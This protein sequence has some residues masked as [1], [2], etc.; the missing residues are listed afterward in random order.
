MNIR[1]RNA[2]EEDYTAAESMMRQV[3]QMHADWRPDIFRYHEPVLPQELFEQA[4]KEKTFFLAEYEGQTA[5]ILYIRYRHI[6][7]PVLVTRNTIFVDTM[8]VDEQYRGR[9]I[10]HAFF[11]FLRE[12]K[13]QKGFDGIE[14]EVNARNTAA[15][16]MYEEY[17]FTVESLNMELL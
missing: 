6:E 11:D 17:G 2:E 10:G 12:L 9:G 8:A 5:G 13:R 7:D 3:H 1:I 16:R 14:L 4:V 15:R